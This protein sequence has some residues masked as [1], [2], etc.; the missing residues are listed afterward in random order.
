MIDPVTLCVYLC[1]CLLCF[2]ISPGGDICTPGQPTAVFYINTHSPLRQPCCFSYLLSKVFHSITHLFHIHCHHI[3]TILAH[4]T[5]VIIII[6]LV[7]YHHHC[8]SHILIGPLTAPV[9]PSTTTVTTVQSTTLPA[10]S[11]VWPHCWHCWQSYGDV[12]IM[13]TVTQIRRLST[14]VVWMT[15]GLFLGLYKYFVWLFIFLTSQVNLW[16]RKKQLSVS[17]CVLLVCTM[18]SSRNQQF[19]AFEKTKPLSLGNPVSLENMKIQ[20]YP[21][22]SSDTFGKKWREND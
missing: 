7:Y 6:I 18:V 5:I 17:L 14:S 16:R 9:P 19:S 4:H 21:R 11:C 20:Y 13:F 15:F 8:T 22:E 2:R 10:D 3:I 1:M 12:R